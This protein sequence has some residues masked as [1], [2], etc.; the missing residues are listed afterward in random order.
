MRQPRLIE[1]YHLSLYVPRQ[2]SRNAAAAI[3]KVLGR[4]D[5][6]AALLRAVRVVLRRHRTLDVVA[7]TLTR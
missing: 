7:V 2:T 1:E 4:R 6:R 5:V 3:S